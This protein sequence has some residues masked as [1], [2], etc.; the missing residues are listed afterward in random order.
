MTGSASW[1]TLTV[2]AALTTAPLSA[3]PSW[4][5]VT[6]YVY[7]FSTTRG[8]SG[9]NATNTQFDNGQA[10]LTLDNRDGRFDP[11][12]TSGAYYPNILPGRRM[13][14]R[15]VWSGGTYP[16]FDGYVNSWGSQYEWDQG[17]LVTVQLTD[18]FLVLGLYQYSPGSVPVET[19]G[20]R[21]SRVLSA[22]GLGTASIDTGL[23]TIIADAALDTL[24]LDHLQACAD[25]EDGQFYIAGDGT[26]VFEDRYHRRTASRSTTS[27][28]TLGDSGTAELEYDTSITTT[29]GDAMLYNGAQV[30]DGGGTVFSYDDATSQTAYLKRTAQKTT[31]GA[32]PNEAY[33][34]AT[35]IVLS[36]K[37]PRL[38]FQS[39]TMNPVFH[40]AAEWPVALGTK[41]SDRLTLKRRPG[42]G[43]TI[44]Q[45]VFVEQITHTVDADS[46][47]TQFEVSP[48]ELS[49]S[50]FAI[51]GTATCDTGSGTHTAVLGF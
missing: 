22:V 18:A 43:N 13:R 35:W 46:W 25:T 39:V 29:Y 32:A 44:T 16:L 33:D 45:D 19:S 27:Q 30:T 41:I 4:T 42:S 9:F 31:I 10:T 50:N 5:D 38:T 21:I 28:A 14:M 47:T 2:E 17:E 20:A 11:T 3:S 49:V 8:R 1:P 48:P 12:F 36:Q 37:D 15:A 40:A 34:Y 23:S 7:N 26:P 51:V 24:A 6:A